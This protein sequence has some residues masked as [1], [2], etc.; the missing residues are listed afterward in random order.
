MSANPATP[1]PKVIVLCFDGTANQFGL[2]VSRP[3]YLLPY[4]AMLTDKKRKNTN[5]VRLCAL[6][7]KRCPL[8]QIV[9]YQ[10]R[11]RAELSIPADPPRSLASELSSSRE[12]SVRP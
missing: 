8:E 2:K 9:Y 10:V 11:F 4:G 7:D 6:L 1:Q 12:S 3:S 5:I